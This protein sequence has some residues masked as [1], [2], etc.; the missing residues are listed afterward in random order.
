MTNQGAAESVEREFNIEFVGFDPAF[1][2]QISQQLKSRPEVE[3][4]EPHL[5]PFV[6][7]MGGP[8]FWPHIV[9]LL[10]PVAIYLGKKGTDFLL[11]YLK[12]TLLTKDKN[13]SAKIKLYGPNGILLGEFAVERDKWYRSY[14]W[15]RWRWRWWNKFWWW[16]ASFKD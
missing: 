4:T 9:V 3:E 7:Y 6:H 2:G 12:D 8:Q 1:V 10:T 11:Q 13:V 5:E 14:R 16:W 15:R